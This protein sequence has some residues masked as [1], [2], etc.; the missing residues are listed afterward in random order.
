MMYKSPSQSPK[1]EPRR[2]AVFRNSVA[3]RFLLDAP[4]TRSIVASL[5]LCASVAVGVAADQPKLV[6]LKKPTRQETIEATLA[7]T[8]LPKVTGNWYYVGPFDNTDGAGFRTAYPPETE[9]EIDLAKS[10][11]GRDGKPVKW[12]E[13]KQFTDGVVNN[14]NLYPQ[15][16]NSCIY[17]AR[18]IFAEKPADLIVSLGSDDTISVWLNGKPL[19]AHD[20]YRAAAPDQERLTL[21]LREGKN[22]LLLKICNYGGP[23]AFY[24][25]PALPS[26][27]EVE[28]N[29]RLARDF[30]EVQNDPESKYYRIVTVPIPD[31]IVLEVGGLAF[32]SDGNLLTCTRRGD[33]FLISSAT[34]DDPAKVSFKRF[35]SGL[36]E[37]LGLLVDGRDV[38]VVQRPELTRLRDT[39]EDDV[40]DEFITVCDRWGVSGDYHE[41]AFGPARDRDGNFFITLNVGFG[42]GHQS[43]APWRGWCVQVSPTGEMTPIA[44]GLRSPN[45]VNFSPD[46]DLFYCDNQGEWVATCKMS[47]IQPGTFHGH[48]A[49]LR[50]DKQLSGLKIPNSG[51]TYD[52]IDPAIP[53]TPPAIWFPYG[54]MGQSTSEPIWD[55]TDG[56]FGP[57]AGQC[58]VGDQTKSNI[59]RVDLEKVN[60]VYQGACFPF[61][62]GF[63]C[64]INRIAFAPDASL[65]VGMTNRGWGSVGGSPYG[66]QQL[67][68]TG[69][70]PFEI[71]SMHLTQTGF[72]LTFTKPLDAD[73]AER[74]FALHKPD[75]PASDSAAR[76]F[77]LQSYTYNYWS[78][79]GSPEIDRQ[80]VAVSAATVSADRRRVSLTVKRESLKSGRVYELHVDGLKSAD[81]DGLLHADAYYTLNELVR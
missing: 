45:G 73:V 33:V 27:V 28:L 15:N 38:Y 34:S 50:W 39:N 60:G 31:D 32:R 64:G 49:G 26:A 3:T 51:Q 44:S 20:A 7:A 43:K 47:H 76:L 70:V 71:Y 68:F 62:S 67:I 42:G 79:Y 35:A 8:G 36:H 75:A 37:P 66:L 80:P 55:T 10:Y 30:P 13:A 69:V 11:A 61:R 72:D 16:E 41:F 77:S 81:G 9:K 65:M 78:T 57:F 46:G 53:L 29:S 6:Y 40:A 74:I 54:K 48:P 24:F 18:E 22:R 23:S 4:L 21:H 1:A 58:F 12:H 17:L 52:A 19:L 14:L 56:K 59:M 25:R 63:Q 5:L 2:F